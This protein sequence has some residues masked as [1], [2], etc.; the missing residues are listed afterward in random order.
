LLF[1]VGVFFG[2]RWGRRPRPDE[3]LDQALKGLD[4]KHTLYHYKSPVNHL[5][6]GPTGVWVL[7]TSPARGTITFSAGRWRQR[8]GNLYFKLFGQ[9]SLGRPDLE[10]SGAVETIERF[11][12]KNLSEEKIPEVQAALVFLN[13][14][15]VIDISDDEQ[16]P[17]ATVS[18]KELK[19]LIRKS[20]KTKSISPEKAKLI[21]EALPTE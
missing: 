5:L 7:Q 19:D 14:A 21:Q 15:T 8:G 6:V 12:N 18:A 16:T 3:V 17:A 4:N 9:E 2:S 11:L 20:G 13:P 1:Q 10:L